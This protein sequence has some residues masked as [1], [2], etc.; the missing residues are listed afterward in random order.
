MTTRQLRWIC[1]GAFWAFVALATCF[2]MAIGSKAE[3]TTGASFALG[4]FISLGVWLHTKADVAERGGD[5]L[6]R[7]APQGQPGRSDKS[8]SSNDWS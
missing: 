5:E 4:M 2:L 7:P 3:M 1:N 8:T 6:P